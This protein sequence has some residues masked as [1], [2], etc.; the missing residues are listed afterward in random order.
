ME[1]FLDVQTLIWLFLVV[2]I[3]HDLEEIMMF[4]AWVKKNK[5]KA[6][7]KLPEKLANRAAK[8]FTM[9]T[10]QLTA[11]VLFIFLIVSSATFMANQYF[12]KGP[13]GNI[14]FFTVLILTFF[15]H[16]FTHVGQSVY[17]KSV[18]PGVITSIFLVMPYSIVM[19]Q[20]LLNA[21]LISWSTIMIC[22]PFVLLMLPIVVFAHWIGKKVV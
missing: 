17:F 12:M 14:H 2:F 9:S 10:A 5:D 13:L 3:I 21:Q 4:E 18:T 11:A 1:R 15:I 8:Q 20:S 7:K 16:V 19:L 6:F 22:L